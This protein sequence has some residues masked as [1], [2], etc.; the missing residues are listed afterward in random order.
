MF[1]NPIVLVVFLATCVTTI[2]AVCE[3]ERG[4]SVIIVDIQESRGEQTNQTTSPLEL[5]IQGE[6]GKIKL[7]IQSATHDFFNIDGKRLI[8]KHP[9]DRDDNRFASL[10]LQILCSEISG[11][12]QRS[13]A[14]VVRLIDVNDNPPQ[15]IATQYFTTVP[16]LSPVGKTIFWNL[17]ARDRD[18]GSNALVEYFAVPG[19]R[20]EYDGYDYFSIPFPH[21]GLVTIK[22]PLDYETTNKLYLKVIAVDQATD[23]NERLTSTTTLTVTVTDEDD[24]GPAFVY[25]G[26]SKLDGAC[27][28][29]QYEATLTSG[30]LVGVL[31]VKPEKIKAKDKDSINSAVHYSFISGTP[32]SFHT[33][34]D[35]DYRSGT[36]RQIKEVDR[37]VFKNFDIVVK[38]EE[39]TEKKRYATAK[40][41]VSIL[42]VDTHPPFIQPT[43]TVGY[44]DENV[45][46]GTTVVTTK[47]GT[48]P[49]KLRVEDID[50][51][52][53]DP[54]QEYQFELTTTVFRVTSDGYIVVN[55][56]GLDSDPPNPKL[57]TFQVTAKQV[58][59]NGSNAASAP[60]LIS[61]HINDVNDNSP[62]L[63]NF[64]PIKIEAG[65]GVRPVTKVQARD[66]DEGDFARISYSIYHVSNNGRNKF[67]I[68]PDEGLVEVTSKISAGEQ[69]SITVQ[70]TDTGGRFSQTIL[71]VIVVPGPNTGGPV[72]SRERYEVQVSEGASI[73]SSVLTIVA[74]DPEKDVIKF[75]IEKGNINNDFAIDP[76]SGVISVANH[77]DREEI[78]AYSLIV[79]AVDP[80]GLFS[81]GTVAITVTDINDQNPVFS[82]ETYEFNVDEG[83]KGNLI[84]KV[85]AHD[86]DIGVN[87]D[88]SYSIT[89][90]SEFS[91][92]HVSGEIYTEKE[93]NYEAQSVYHLV[94]T[95]QDKAPDA[96]ISTAS[97][98]VYVNDVEDEIPIFKVPL[99]EGNVPENAP[100]YEVVQVK[101]TDPDQVFKITYTI[102]E[103]DRQL[104]H[105]DPETGMVKTN[106]GLDFEKQRSHKLVIGTLENPT[107]DPMARATVH[108]TV[109]DHNDISPMFT[110]LPLPIRLQD[111]VPLGT[112]VTTV[113]AS[114]RD[115][116]SPNNQVRYELSTIQPKIPN[117]FLVDRNSGVISVK[118]DLRKERDS[119]YRIEI[120]A[121]DS[122]EP[123]YSSTATVTVYVEHLVTVAPDA[124]L[125]FAD[126]HYNVEVEENALANTLV[127]TLTVINKPKGNFP[128]GCEVI[129]GNDDDYFYV[130]DNDHRD[131]ELR[132]KRHG[133]DFEKKSRHMLIIRLITA[134]GLIG[135]NRMTTQVMVNIVDMNDNRPEF[136]LPQRYVQYTKDKYLAALP[137]DAA[138]GTQFVQVAA[139]DQ[140]SGAN[141]KIAYEIVPI[142][143]TQQYFKI[144]HENGYLSNSKTFEDVLPEDLPLK[145][146]ITAMDNPTAGQQMKQTTEVLINL[147]DESN[148]LVMALKDTLPDKAL[149]IR[150]EIIEILQQHTNMV[151]DIEKIASLKLVRNNSIESD[152]TGT[153]IWFYVIDPQTFRILSRDD[154]RI[155]EA[156]FKDERQMTILNE[157]SNALGAQAHTIREPYVITQPVTVVT[158]E[159]IRPVK[160]AADV[161]D[162]G[163]S[164]IALACIIVVLTMIGIVYHCCMWS[165]YVSYK[166]RVKRMYI[167]ARYDPMVVESSLKEYE[168]QV[169]QMSVPIDE[170]GSV[171]EMNVSNEVKDI[172]N[173]SYLSKKKG[174]QF[175]EYGLDQGDYYRDMSPSPEG[176]ASFI[177][178]SPTTPNSSM[179]AE[180][181]ER[182]VKNPLFEDYNDDDEII[183]VFPNS[184]KNHAYKENTT[185][186]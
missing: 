111:N 127:K 154:P 36:V 120:I 56:A 107:S 16:E 137:Y 128:I 117:Y 65:K 185:M 92:K 125:G 38:A 132:V 76:T 119:E 139:K 177:K 1:L 42:A 13:I 101:A 40:L 143:R 80:N 39:Q 98:T 12:T 160:L 59:N 57:H 46:V 51:G 105:V 156:L 89:G 67:R 19:D 70:A 165:R 155:V 55:E 5:P 122:G 25:E 4:E 182:A 135:S 11:N 121:H 9:I 24:Q 49:L 68:D 106:E 74:S 54:K 3:T 171:S 181:D 84:G 129:S 116:T 28:N 180:K 95:A 175:I 126:Q 27:V 102:K 75:S 96:R 149:D 45:P 34:F 152:K 163:A 170:E 29:P 10:R 145:V 100:N 26:C 179:S 58:G 148:R 44:V 77:L 164:L 99:Y 150:E 103:G 33:Y 2:I 142:E 172:D 86:E 81:T 6:P 173:V 50:I 35:I 144:D 109:Q 7:S 178:T 108:I 113:V 63:P 138:A 184:G 141:G 114:D 168:T 166:E 32:P 104:F 158:A 134:G 8:L 47:G 169:L 82:K 183:P 85:Q 83:V 78:S 31:D 62:K 20:P 162:L 14:V 23:K 71:D 118:D 21:Q 131:C 130:L 18:A 112:V 140:D 94:V 110:S 73:N 48:E 157:M 60:V 52:A 61:V 115:G 72:L 151:V 93:L 90:S 43:S 69:Y 88:I 153:D 22:N 37:N 64:T 186:L 146:R 79:K 124:G 15:F 136:V 174:Q 147:V 30:T 66:N 53:D 176:D 133:I 123:S 87:G 41:H 91:I 159:S 97:V 17:S 161:G 167:A